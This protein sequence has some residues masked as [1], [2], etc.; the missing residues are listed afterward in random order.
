MSATRTGFC[1]V[2][3]GVR[4][5]ACGDDE[6]TALPKSGSGER[7]ADSTI[8]EWLA[9]CGRWG[10]A[11][12]KRT[13]D[14]FV[15]GLDQEFPCHTIGDRSAY[16]AVVRR[17][18]VLPRARVPSHRHLCARGQLGRDEPVHCS[19]DCGT[20]RLWIAERLVWCGG[21]VHY[22]ARRRTAEGT[23]PDQDARDG[24][25]TDRAHCQDFER[26][27]ERAGLKAT[28]GVSVTSSSHLFYVGGERLTRDSRSAR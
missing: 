8:A 11:V 10:I 20:L 28:E 3:S 18:V 12:A 27:R 22:P 19:P 26:S 23:E 21:I 24:T 15:C 1:P 16:V 5:I 7:S 9:E 14:S 4:T 17:A 13:P 2:N 25:R 6:L